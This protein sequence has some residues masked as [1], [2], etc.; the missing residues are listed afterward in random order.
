VCIYYYFVGFENARWEIATIYSKEMDKEK[1]ALPRPSEQ[2]ANPENFTSFDNNPGRV[3]NEKDYINKII[4]NDNNQILNKEMNDNASVAGTMSGNEDGGLNSGLTGYQSKYTA[5]SDSSMFPRTS[6]TIPSNTATPSDTTVLSTD[7]NDRFDENS[8]ERAKAAWE[9]AKEHIKE[10]SSHQ[11]DNM[12]DRTENTKE[13]I[14]QSIEQSA[15]KLK[16]KAEQT[17]DTISSKWDNTKA[18]A[19]DKFD[20]AK[21][22]FDESQNAMKGRTERVKN[23]M[24]S[25]IE[26]VKNTTKD[27]LENVKETA[28]EKLEQ[29]KDK[30]GLLKAETEARAEH[31]KEQIEARFDDAKKTLENA[32]ESAKELVTTTLQN[33]RDKISDSIAGTKES[34][35]QTKE[36]VTSSIEHAKDSIGSKM[37]RAKETVTSKFEDTKENMK[38]GAEQIKSN[39]ESLKERTREKTDETFQRMKNDRQTQIEQSEP[40]LRGAHSE[41]TD[42][43]AMKNTTSYGTMSSSPGITSRTE[44]KSDN[45]PQQINTEVEHGSGSGILGGLKEK[46]SHTLHGPMHIL[47]LDEH[48]HNERQ[49]DDLTSKDLPFLPE[50]RRR[51]DELMNTS[52]STG[53][54]DKTSEAGEKNQDQS[55][56]ELEKEIIMSGM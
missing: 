12:S 40:L 26:Q 6:H 15:D 18:T 3:F 20:S 1:A 42:S 37:E 32:T 11:S 16:S 31:T 21:E 13:R 9:R 46:L 5:Q 43:N 47:L 14:E 33:T 17:N 4:P 36:N 52:D 8:V 55:I 28:K 2:E 34:L 50:S 39:V 22:S 49:R 27:K 30:V 24:S 56:S 10:L 38:S 48:A 45:E 19:K 41:R 23:A 25:N 44:P 53:L 35:K 51:S 54:V 29:T 7:R